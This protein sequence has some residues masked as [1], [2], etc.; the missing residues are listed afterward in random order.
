MSQ[1]KIITRWEDIAERQVLIGEID[2]LR[3]LN[4]RL[5]GERD[6][7]RNSAILHEAEA[8]ALA[9]ELALRDAS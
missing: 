4:A 5:A 9:I 2:K 3:T 1:G 6:R 8:E 7:A